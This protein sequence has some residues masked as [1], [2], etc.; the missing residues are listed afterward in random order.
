MTILHTQKHMHLYIHTTHA[1]TDINTYTHKHIDRH[2]P[3]THTT[4]IDI[5]TH[6]HH[7]HKYHTHTYTKT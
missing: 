4:H 1:H 2:T 6:K 3:Y 7:T 5:I